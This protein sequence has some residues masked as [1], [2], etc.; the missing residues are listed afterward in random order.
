[1][2]LTVAMAIIG[3]GWAATGVGLRRSVRGEDMTQ[4]SAGHLADKTVPWRRTPD[5]RPADKFGVLHDGGRV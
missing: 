5:N 2:D 4:S 1:M 3:V